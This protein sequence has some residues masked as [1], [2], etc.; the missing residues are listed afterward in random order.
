VDGVAEFKERTSLKLRGVVCPDHHQAPKLR[1]AGTSLRNISI[2]LSGC[3]DKLITLAN[4][5]IRS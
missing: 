2:Q 5:A 1:F 3:C 4:Q